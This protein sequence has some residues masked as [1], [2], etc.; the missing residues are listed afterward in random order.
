MSNIPENSVLKKPRSRW[1]DVWD[2]FKSHKGALAGGIVF[3]F[4]VGAVYII[5]LLYTSP[6]PRDS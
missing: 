3:I 6:S 1:L 4:I 5:C 2:Q